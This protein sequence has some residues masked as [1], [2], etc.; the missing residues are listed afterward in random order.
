MNFFVAIFQD[1]ADALTIF[2]FRGNVCQKIPSFKI[3]ICARLSYYMNLNAPADNSQS[4]MPSYTQLLFFSSVR[5]F[6]SVENW[7]GLV[8]IGGRNSKFL[9]S[10]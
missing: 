2:L 3:K 8:S 4:E 6:F 10:W 9:L 1:T 5:R 7:R